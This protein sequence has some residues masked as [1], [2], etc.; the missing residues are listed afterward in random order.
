M[1]KQQT[2]TTTLVLGMGISG[3]AC[4]RYLSKQNIK[5]VMAD[6]RAQPPGLVEFKTNFVNSDLYLG[7]FANLSLDGID[8]IV[9]SPGLALELPIVQSALAQGI[10]VIGEI[11]LFAQA[12]N[13]PVVAITGS[14]GKST[15]TTLFGLMI[16]AA[17]R[18]VCVGGNLGTA[19]LDLLTTPAPT[20]Y[21]LELSSFQLET[22]FSLKPEVAIVLNVSED[23]MDRYVDLQAYA[24]TK[25]RIY[26][27]AKF[28]IV[29]RDDA[30][31]KAMAEKLSNVISFGLD[32]PAAQQY[33]LSFIDEQNYLMR[34]N[35]KLLAVSELKIAG[36][37]NAANVLA[38][39][40]MGEALQL[41]MTAMLQAAR[42]FAG[43]PH[44]CNLVAQYKD[45]RFYNDSKATNIG[46]AAA[47]LN[48]M[49]Q[50]VILIAG[51]DGKGADFKT[52]RESVKNKV[53]AIILLGRDAQHIADA[54][55]DLTQCYFVSDMQAAVAKSMTLMTAG[56]VVM[57]SP[58][59]A[60]LDMYRN[61]AHRGDEFTSCVQALTQ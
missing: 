22:T 41:P 42:E 52:L 9:L 1:T 21:V 47:A 14:N 54:V 17:N 4:A 20:A 46:A 44:R 48:G 57:L 49:T 2:A 6:T 34:G 19:A 38:C 5:F 27:Y 51:G 43:L 53:K 32:Q 37:H 18:S 55:S 29:N 13:A 8:R 40:A 16:A 24:D 56:D 28:N 12:V 3:M 26:K 60:S 59:C 61:Y 25:A 7:D 39:L 33:G 35:E 10:E 30:V 15:V 45:V 23:H 31:V 11:E 50:P 58:A 36:L